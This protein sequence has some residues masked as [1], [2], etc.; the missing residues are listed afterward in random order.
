M[1][2]HFHCL[3]CPSFGLMQPMDIILQIKKGNARAG[4]NGK[5]EREQGA[6]TPRFYG[7]MKAK[8]I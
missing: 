6:Q 2:E 1:G 4:S 3:K 7:D 5:F 8:H